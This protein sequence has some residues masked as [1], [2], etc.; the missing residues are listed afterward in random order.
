[1]R[2]DPDGNKLFHSLTPGNQRLSIQLVNV[3]SDIDT[4]IYR[5][6]RLIEYLKHTEG[7]FVYNEVN[8]ALKRS[9]QNFD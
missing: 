4:R 8:N 2:Q 7:K 5:S 3:T 9:V 6:L 1:M